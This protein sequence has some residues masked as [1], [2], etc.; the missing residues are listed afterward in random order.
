MKSFFSVQIYV[1]PS[2]LGASSSRILRERHKSAE[3]ANI[4][5]LAMQVHS[6]GSSCGLFRPPHHDSPS[7][8][9]AF[10]IRVANYSIRVFGI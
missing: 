5:L 3:Q 8:A 7:F 1:S 6:R 2:P 10:C 9:D 4:I